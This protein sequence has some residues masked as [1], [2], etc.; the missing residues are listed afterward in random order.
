MIPRPVRSCRPLTARS[1]LCAA[2]DAVD[3]RYNHPHDP[4]PE[5][6]YMW[7]CKRYGLRDLVGSTRWDIANAVDTYHESSDEVRLFASFMHE[8]YGTEQ[9]SFFLY[10]RTVVYEFSSTTSRGKRS[11]FTAAHI[12]S[13]TMSNHAVGLQLQS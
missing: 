8:K 5:F 9:L 7:T 3:N 6:I 10:C 13:C 1:L 4:L 11:A 2:A 12:Y